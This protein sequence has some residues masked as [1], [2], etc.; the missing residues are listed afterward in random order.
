[1]F[2]N[3][4][5]KFSQHGSHR[6]LSPLSL[7]QPLGIPARKPQLSV[8]W[9]GALTPLPSPP[10]P[11]PPGQQYFHFCDAFLGRRF[12]YQPLRDLLGTPGGGREAAAPAAELPPGWLEVQL[13]GRCLVVTAPLKDGNCLSSVP[14][15]ACSPVSVPDRCSLPCFING[16]N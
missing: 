7:Q 1:M 13:Q 8:R 14:L 10:P 3:A 12:R 11:Q 6:L 4:D 2:R 9:G 15:H 5:L 16:P